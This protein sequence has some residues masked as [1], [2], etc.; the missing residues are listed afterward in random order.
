MIVDLNERED[1]FLKSA[2]VFVRILGIRA[3]LGTYFWRAVYWCRCN[4]LP[5]NRGERYVGGGGRLHISRKEQ[6]EF[7]IMSEERR[8]RPKMDLFETKNPHRGHA[9]HNSEWVWTERDIQSFATED[10]K[11]MQANAEKLVRK[12]FE[13]A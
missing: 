3:A 8:A 7:G 13:N 1:S 4:L 12:H 6:R 10:V 9:Y 5:W 11:R 2:W